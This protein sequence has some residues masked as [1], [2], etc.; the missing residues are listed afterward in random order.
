MSRLKK[1]MTSIFLIFTLLI[2]AQNLGRSAKNASAINNTS[3]CTD[4]YVV[5]AR[6]SG[7]PLD[8]NIDHQAFSKTIKT[9]FQKLNGPTYQYYQLGESN[10]Y[11]ATYPA[12]GIEQPE[13]IAGAIISGGKAFD[14][15]QSV[16]A[17]MEELKDLYQKVSTTCPKTRFILAGYSQG[18]MV[19]SQTLSVFNPDKLFYYASFGDP[20]LYLPEGFGLFPHACRNQSLSPYRQNVPDCYV[21]HGLLGGLKPYIASEFND[22]VGAWC[23]IADFICGS[24]IDPFGFTDSTQDP[25]NDTLARIFN[26]HVS[27]SRF[28]A[29]REAADVIY[30]KILK[31]QTFLN[32]NPTTKKQRLIYYYDQGDLQ[33]TSAPYTPKANI[34]PKDLHI[35]IPTLISYHEDSRIQ[36]LLNKIV[37]AAYRNHCTSVNFY[38][39]GYYRDAEINDV[40]IFHPQ[41]SE[42]FPKTSLKEGI[43]PG[44]GLYTE[45]L[46]PFGAS[47]TIGSYMKKQQNLDKINIPTLINSSL[48]NIAKHDFWDKNHDHTLLVITP[49]NYHTHEFQNPNPELI[50]KTK[51]S[52]E[53]RSISTYFYNTN[54]NL[55]NFLKN[56]RIT[57]TQ[58]IFNQKFKDETIISQLY[59]Q[60]QENP[61]NSVE[62]LIK[63]R[64]DS[65]NLGFSDNLFNFIP[66]SSSKRRLNQL[67]K[68]V[69]LLA[70]LTSSTASHKSTS[71]TRYPVSKNALYHWKITQDGQVKNIESASPN[72]NLPINSISHAKITLKDSSDSQAAL[73][74]HFLPKPNSKDINRPV[75]SLDPAIKAEL[76]PY[77][78]IIIDNYLA[79]FT[80]QKHLT[81]TELDPNTTHKIKVVHFSNFGRKVAEQT[82][83]V[84]KK[85]IL[86]KTKSNHTKNQNVQKPSISTID[87]PNLPDCGT[88]SLTPIR[89][90]LYFTLYFY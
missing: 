3:S 47:N 55:D 74:L 58:N 5:F 28:G 62:N 35:L 15:G 31:E 38:S 66:N 60:N 30:R 59:Q 14:F 65:L 79:G 6:G 11:R 78:L 29:Y 36:R 20:K 69:S 48:E 1:F 40:K 16:K 63:P 13:I 90:P 53:N 68:P 8:S 51:F 10:E 77:R 7:E 33:K 72:I 70:P 21:E 12:I 43:M 2:L 9:I 64:F 24:T 32:T 85:K 54:S 50:K 75:G 18:A 26:G 41:N 4:F 86:S 56:Y 80:K 67:I 52:L 42:S 71:Y 22:K 44:I 34:S 49:I 27:Y 83:T 39:Y 82:I 23:N 76:F 73:D 87:V 19:I 45:R 57:K 61:K 84:P 37:D 46:L 25:K 81:I 88:K 17:G 89:L